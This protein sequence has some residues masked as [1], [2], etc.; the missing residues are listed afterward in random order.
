MLIVY[1]NRNEMAEM[2]TKRKLQ[3]ERNSAAGT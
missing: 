3:Q 2:E 1:R